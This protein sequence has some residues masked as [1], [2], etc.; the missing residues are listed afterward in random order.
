MGSSESSFFLTCTSSVSSCSYVL[1]ARSLSMS[2]ET[3]LVLRES[4]P[5]LVLRRRSLQMVLSA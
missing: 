4:R 2:A 1:G 3:E 5:A